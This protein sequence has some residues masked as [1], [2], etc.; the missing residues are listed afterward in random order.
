[1]NMIILTG[2]SASGKTLI[3]YH[4]EK[5][6]GIKKAITSTTREKRVN[7]VN[8]VDY[9]FVDKNCFLKMI[10]D[11]L[12]V[13]H[14]IYNSNYYGCTKKEVGDN[15]VVV[16]EPEGLKNFKALNDEHIVSFYIFAPEEIRHQRM[17]DRLDKED[18]IKERLKNDKERFD[19]NK[20]SDIDFIINNYNRDIDDVTDEI[21]LKYKNVIDKK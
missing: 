13:E 16:L 21:Y 14:T 3:D 20:I 11:N 4:L 12:L 15:K 5:K 17:I 8:G 6:Y 10:E 1:M 2:P 19:I 7:E 18:K 9:Y